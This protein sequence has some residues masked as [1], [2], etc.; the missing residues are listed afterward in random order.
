[1]RPRS[2]Q[3][4]RVQ[5]RRI[6]AMSCDTKSTDSPEVAGGPDALLA[7]A[8]ELRVADGEHLV[9]EHHLGAQAD[10]RR[11]P[12]LHGAAARTVAER[13]VGLR[14]KP[15]KSRIASSAALTCRAGT[16]ASRP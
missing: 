5:M 4:T 12:Q 10:D 15:A 16:P 11:E 13:L 1:M 3:M 8:A 7:R 2:I 9:G 6:A 14:R